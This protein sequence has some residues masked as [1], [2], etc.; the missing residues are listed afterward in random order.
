M[1][2]KTGAVYFDEARLVL[3]CRTLY[4]Q[5]IEEDHFLEA[6]IVDQVYTARDFHR[7]YVGE[8]VRVLTR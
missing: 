1:P 8:I 3:E 6:S 5:D 2:G 4:K 7:M